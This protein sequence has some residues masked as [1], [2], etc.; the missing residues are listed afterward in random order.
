MDYATHNRLHGPVSREPVIINGQIVELD[1]A[2]SLMDDEICEAI[3]GTVDTEQ[4]FVDAYLVAH[5]R[6][7]GA[8]F[9]IG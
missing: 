4:E 9:V 8:P 3:H 2:R 5:E 7:F 1:V 6:K